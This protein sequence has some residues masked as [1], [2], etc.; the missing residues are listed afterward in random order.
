MPGMSLAK[1]VKQEILDVSF[2]RMLLS[3]LPV[4]YFNK[5]ITLKL[6]RLAI[7]RLN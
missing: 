7:F 6:Q 1:R 3:F 5:E 4:K 2:H